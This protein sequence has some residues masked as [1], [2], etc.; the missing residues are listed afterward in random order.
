MTN[1]CI[2]DCKYCINRCSNSV[3]RAT[4]TPIEVANLT[5]EFYK[6]NYIEGLFLSSAVIKSPDYTMEQLYKA[7]SILRNEYN[8]NGYIHAK[9]IPGAS[10]ELIN[11]L[12]NLV[13]R[14]SI[15]I[16]LPSND[17]LK[18]LAPQKEKSNIFTPM[19]HISTN[20]AISEKEKSHYAKRFVPAR[21]NNTSYDWCKS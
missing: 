1:A 2:Y 17:S 11:K 8:F 13:D 20:I 5:I 14:M 9:A 15:N 16:E 18:L 3:P 21:S 7:I 4:F 12:G 10:Q 19:K 6:R